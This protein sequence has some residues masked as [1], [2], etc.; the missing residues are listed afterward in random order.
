MLGDGMHRFISVVG[1]SGSGKS[2]L[3]WAGLLPALA[4]GALPGSKDWVQLRFTPAERSENPFIELASAL[5]RAMGKPGPEIRQMA[6]QLRTHSEA[7][8]SYLET[9]LAGKPQWAELL[10]F[11]DQCEEFFTLVDP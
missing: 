2:S 8:H 4:K 7:S 11:I 9:V 3:V 1:A 10:L 6:E 5:N